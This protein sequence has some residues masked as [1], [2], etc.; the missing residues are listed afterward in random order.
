[1]RKTPQKCTSLLF[2]L[3]GIMT[4]SFCSNAQE[5]VHFTT[6]NSDS[7]GGVQDVEAALTL[8]ADAA[9]GSKFPAVILVH[10]AWG[11]TEEGVTSKYAA[12]LT[13]AGFITLEPHLFANSRDIKAG[14]PAAY[15]PHAFGALKYMASRPDVDPQRI[16]LAGYSFGGQLSL[17]SATSWAATNYGSSGTRFGAFA[18]F[19]PV[20]WIF[21]AN[22]TGQ[23]KSPVPT[24][25]WSHWTVAPVRIYAG[26]IDDYDDRDP[27]ACQTFVNSIPASEQ[28][29]FSVRVFPDA[30]H[31]WDQ[32]RSAD[33]FVKYA[34]KGRGCLNRNWQNP[35]ATK[36][37]I[38]DLIEFFAKAMPQ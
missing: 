16:G 7:S 9:K 15:L 14:G 17:V 25:A 12:A 26:A 8:P 4:T 5:V 18:I 19:Y 1:M 23:R 37:S 35:E 6:V 24:D 33:F 38:S 21:S 2:A 20:C 28:K 36:Q 34:C 10:S 27:N 29:S 22:A 30:T 13:K 31:G 3:L 11:W 32:T